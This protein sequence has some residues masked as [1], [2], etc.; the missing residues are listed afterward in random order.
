MM[1]LTL[2]IIVSIVAILLGTLI[3]F[4]VTH[5]KSSRYQTKTEML[6][7]EKSN[8]LQELKDKSQEIMTLS[9]D[10]TSLLSERSSLRTEVD[11]LNQK[12]VDSRDTISATKKQY[13][14]IITLLRE[15]GEKRKKELSD[16][17]K[18]QLENTSNNYEKRISQIKQHHE[19]Q[20]QEFRT[21]QKEQ[22]DQQMVLIRE[23]MNSASE[24]ILKERSIELAASN[25]E[26][27]AN[28]LNPLKEN[29]KQMKDAVE[30]SD[31]EQTTTMERLDA[32]IKENL[33]QAKEVGERADKLAQALTSENKSQGNF[34]ELRLKQLL[35]S[36]GLEEG[37]QFEEQTAIRDEKGNVLYD[38]GHRLIPDV[39]LHF[40]DNRDIVIDSKISLSAF[41]DY[42][43]ADSDDERKNA[44]H[45]HI[46]SVRAHVQELSRKNYSRN[47][48]DSRRK[49]DFVMMYVFSESALQLALSNDPSL[50]K[51]AYDKGVIISGSQSLYMM[52]RILEMTWRQV[53][54]VENQHE[55]MK[56]ANLII[57]RVQMFYER[58]QNVDEQLQK[59]QVAF[60]KLKG[61]TKQDGASIA[62]AA[63]NL[64][65]FGAQENIKKKRLPKND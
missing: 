55:M 27:L 48:S 47:L 29:I 21:T 52:L 7:Q 50:W 18:E 54:Q 3:G 12:I 39:I 36:M 42:Y 25:Q 17:Y 34:G 46:A 6:E 30:K 59:T 33:K 31:R 22:M 63:N 61:I 40:P 26:Q 49:L 60:D 1:D 53:R 15:E 11:N 44:L 13:E 57:E 19:E 38:E 24:K 5:S 35:E 16:Q 20:L 32:S 23:Q 8:L 37:I 56:T 62:T 41:Q 43:N 14:D 4:L 58:F 10:K 9:N 28:I 65:K 2:L 45:R 51:D 64:L